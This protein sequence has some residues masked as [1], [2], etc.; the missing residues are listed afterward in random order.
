MTDGRKGRTEED[1][2]IAAARAFEHPALGLQYYKNSPSRIDTL[3][4]RYK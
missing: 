3:N 2:C 4:M 1:L